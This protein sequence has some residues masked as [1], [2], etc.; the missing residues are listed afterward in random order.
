M[1]LSYKVKKQ[2]KFICNQCGLDYKHKRSLIF[3]KKT[4]HRIKTELS[5]I[6]KKKKCKVMER[7][8]ILRRN[9]KIWKKKLRMLR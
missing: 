2:K 7:K 9:I 1:A 8:A 5:E 3:H 4:K 6:K